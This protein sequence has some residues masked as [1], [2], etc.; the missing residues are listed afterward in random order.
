MWPRLPLFPRIIV[1]IQHV[2]APEDD[3]NVA[4]HTNLDHF[5]SGLG[6]VK[7]A[8]PVLKFMRSSLAVD[9]IVHAVCSD[10]TFP[11]D[12]RLS[13]RPVTVLRIV[14]AISKSS[15]AWPLQATC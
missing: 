10:Y 15:I 4:G 6:L 2:P 7:S 11:L 3:L 13:T 12:E 8:H 5:H 14:E 1:D 9:V